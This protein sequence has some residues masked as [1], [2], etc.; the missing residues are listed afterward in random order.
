MEAHACFVWRLK[1]W[2]EN[3]FHLNIMLAFEF[4]QNSDFNNCVVDPKNLTLQSLG[5]S[6]EFRLSSSPAA[7]V[8]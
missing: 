3:R 1:K 8:D 7:I 5:D 6:V 2:K 4:D